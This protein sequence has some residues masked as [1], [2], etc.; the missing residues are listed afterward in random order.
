[1]ECYNQY[2]E[3]LDLDSEPFTMPTRV[4]LD[5]RDNEDLVMETLQTRYDRIIDSWQQQESD[6]YQSRETRYDNEADQPTF[7]VITRQVRQSGR[8]APT[9]VL[10]DGRRAKLLDANRV[11][12][13]CGI[14]EILPLNT[15]HHP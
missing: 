1:M 4:V 5:L 11:Q 6:H 15:L 14:Q 7:P 12:T 10:P 9:V 8:T 13:L 2:N 3:P